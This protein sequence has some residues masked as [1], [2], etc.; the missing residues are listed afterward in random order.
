MSF[1]RDRRPIGTVATRPDPMTWDCLVAPDHLVLGPGREVFAP[2]N[3]WLP[4]TSR[5]SNLQRELA[6]VIPGVSPS[7]TFDS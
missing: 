1:L 2:K 3:P 5:S 4:G 7:F 6:R